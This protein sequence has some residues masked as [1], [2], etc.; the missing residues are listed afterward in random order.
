ML[1]YNDTEAREERATRAKRS[2]RDWD[3]NIRIALKSSEPQL[4]RA[5]TIKIGG[6]GRTSWQVVI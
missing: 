4:V 2:G 3:N 6:G 5:P 1:G